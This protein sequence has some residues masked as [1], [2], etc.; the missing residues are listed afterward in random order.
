MP[1]P[2]LQTFNYFGLVRFTPAYWSLPPADRRRMCGEWL[3]RLDGAADRLHVYQ[4]FGPEAAHDLVLWSALRTVGPDTPQRFFTGFASAIAPVR[5]Y[6]TLCHTLWG[7]TR[8][9]QYTKTRST[10]ELDPFAADRAPYLIIYP[11]VKTAAWY[12]RARPERQEMMAQHIRVGKQYK[13][14]TQLLLYSFGL[15][16][17]EFVV[18]YETDNLSRFLALVEELRGTEAR[19]FTE[20]D[21]PLHLGI[22]QAD[23]E[24]LGAWL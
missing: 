16:D 17:Q 22:H 19:L 2:T 21:T 5:Q 7:L 20:R 11:F 8:P 4:S 15:Q 10:Q 1:E 18:V 6:V 9:S 23:R 3:E 13:D 14:I 24:A 12:L